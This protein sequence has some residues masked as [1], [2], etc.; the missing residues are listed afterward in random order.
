MGVPGEGWTVP[1]V[2]SDGVPDGVSP[3]DGDWPG[4]VAVPVPPGDMVGVAV[5]LADLDGVGDRVG[6]GE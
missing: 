2:P 4:D 5:G 3:G 6:V 1:G